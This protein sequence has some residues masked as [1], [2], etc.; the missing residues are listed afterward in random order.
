VCGILGILSPQLPGDMVIR[1]AL[2][3][4]RH[5]GPDDEGYLFIDTSGEISLRASG[6]DTCKEL[7]NKY[8]DISDVDIAKF[9]LLLAHRRLSILDLSSRGHQPMSYADGDLLITY[10]GEIF[11]YRELRRELRT[12]GYRFNSDTDTEVIL[13]AYQ[14]WGEQCVQ[15]FNGQWSFCIFDRKQKRLFCSRDRFGIKPFYYSFDKKLFA[16]A[17]EIKALLMLPFFHAELNKRVVSDFLV[18]CELDTSEETPYKGVYQLPPAHNLVVD[19]MGT[20]PR[21]E[22]YYELGFLDEVGDYDHQQALRYAD[23]IRNLLI[24]A[25]KIRLKSDVPVGTCLSGGL[26]SSSIAVVINK[27]LND[28]GVARE[29]IGEK[30][31]TFTASYDDP[32]IDER[33]YANEV[34]R[35]INVSA[36]F[37]YPT[38]DK[39]WEEL[40]RFLYLQD[41]LCFSTNVYAG[42]DVMRLASQHVKVVLNGEGGDELFGGYH[43]YEILYL[44]DIIRDWHPGDLFAALSGMVHRHGFARTASR[45]VLGGCLALSSPC[46]KTLLFKKLHRTQRIAAEDLLNN[47][48]PVDGHLTKMIDSMK[49]LNHFLS[50]ETRMTYLPQLLHYDDRNA[51]AFSIENRVPFVDHRLVEYVHA[52]P[53]IYKLYKGWSKWLLRLAMRDLLPEKILWRKDKLGF[54]TPVK[55]WLTHDL[56]P[57]PQLMKRYGIKKYNHFAWRLFIADRLIN[58]HNK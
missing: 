43:R 2:H 53:A 8:G 35:H 26:E 55:A 18:F 33:I 10:N 14:E 37:S 9:D 16:F 44:A 56:S 11:N 17:S 22:K 3:S 51:S 42:W 25:V 47:A 41:R 39:L 24:D 5:R 29:K 12:S 13:A 48:S 52:I 27:L 4:I 28:K 54:P 15:K 32:S 31:K 6:S 50:Y 40:E 34:I 23:D 49:S 36:Y 20:H 1:K 46:L 7:R 21:Q 38:A 19:L 57:V 30:Q 58:N 45:G